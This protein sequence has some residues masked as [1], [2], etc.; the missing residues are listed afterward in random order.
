MGNFNQD[1]L[2]YAQQNVGTQVW[3]SDSNGNKLKGAFGECWDLGYE[4]LRYAGAKKTSATY[5]WG[6][7][8][9]FSSAQPGDIIQFS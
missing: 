5:V 8:V 1:T 9:T 3:A 2:K 6:Q 4:A 7:L